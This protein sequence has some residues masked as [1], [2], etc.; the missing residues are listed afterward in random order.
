MRIHLSHKN[1]CDYSGA[2]PVFW[3]HSE[4]LR[5]CLMG[6]DHYENQSRRAFLSLSAPALLSLRSQGSPSS[7]SDTAPNLQT[8]FRPNLDQPEIYAFMADEQD[9]G[10]WDAPLKPFDP[11][12]FELS[13]SGKKST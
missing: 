13:A 8:D 12:H 5:R 1:H 11:D 6:I 9:Q 10:S 4:T 2:K 3:G 7:V